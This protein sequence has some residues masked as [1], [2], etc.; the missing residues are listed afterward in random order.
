MV[1]EQLWCVNCLW[2]WRLAQMYRLVIVGDIGVMSCLPEPKGCSKTPKPQPVHS[3]TVWQNMQDHQITEQLF[4]SGCGT[5]QFILTLDG[6]YLLKCDSFCYAIINSRSFAASVHV[7]CCFDCISVKWHSC[8]RWQMMLL[9]VI[10]PDP[11]LQGRVRDTWQRPPF[12]FS[13]PLQHLRA[14]RPTAEWQEIWQAQH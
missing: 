5:P 2:L 13:H 9:V 1:Y 8:G 12:V 7:V 11:E 10:K 14:C 6:S 4:S 3:A